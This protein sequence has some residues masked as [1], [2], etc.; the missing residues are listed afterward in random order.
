VNQTPHQKVDLLLKENIKKREPS[1]LTM[2]YRIGAIL[3]MVET[4]QIGTQNVV[5]LSN[6]PST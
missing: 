1:K 4:G 3:K 2:I 6:L 5:F